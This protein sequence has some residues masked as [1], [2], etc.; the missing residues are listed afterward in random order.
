MIP[1][2]SDVAL[3]LENRPNLS[4]KTGIAANRDSGS[5]TIDTKNRGYKI[6]VHSEFIATN[7]A[8]VDVK[9]KNGIG[10][11]HN[12]AVPTEP[13]LR[14]SS[15][16]SLAIKTRGVNAEAYK[17]FP[18][19]LIHSPQQQ[20][21]CAQLKTCHIPEES[22]AVQLAAASAANVFHAACFS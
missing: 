11:K 2:P 6:I 7:L 3:R 19:K 20:S 14:S 10:K 16:S 12:E 4:S 21:Q 13:G 22:M 9:I 18:R 15:T 17:M 1:F 8:R 5:I